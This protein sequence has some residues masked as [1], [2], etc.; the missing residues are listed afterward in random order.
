MK[1]D[2]LTLI[3]SGMVCLCQFWT[4][5]ALEQGKWPEIKMGSKH[6]VSP[7]ATHNSATH[8]CS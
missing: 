3:K 7:I 4:E 1:T 6:R 8:E 5:Q 2:M